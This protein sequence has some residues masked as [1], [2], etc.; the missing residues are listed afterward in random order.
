MGSRIKCDVG[1]IFNNKRVGWLL[2]TSR[3]C[4]LEFFSVVRALT[5]SLSF[6]TGDTGNASH[7]D[8]NNDLIIVT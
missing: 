8:I 1:S 5:N 6:S 3:A 2:G 4:S 7:D